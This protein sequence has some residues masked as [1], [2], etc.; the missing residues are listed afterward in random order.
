MSFEHGLTPGDTIKNDKLVEIFKCSPQGGMRKSN[1]TNTL[2]VVSNHLKSI[3]EDRW[4]NDVLHYTGMGMTGD[5]CR[6]SLTN[7][8]IISRSTTF[9][10]LTKK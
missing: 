9:H 10:L 3:Y 4:V 2:L 1:Q 5:Q 7:P 8:T 6:F